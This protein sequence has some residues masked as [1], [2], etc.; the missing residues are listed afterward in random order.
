MIPD[1]LVVI[2]KPAGLTSQQVVNRAK[3]RLADQA[4]VPAKRLKAGHA[5]TLDP[6]ATGVLVVG[7]GRATRLLGYV[8]GHDKQYLATIRLGQA[9]TTDDAE[10]EPVGQPVDATGLTPSAIEA[11]IAP[12]TGDIEQV[13]SSVSAIKVDGKRAYALARAGEAVTLRSRPVTVSRFEVLTRHDDGP[14]VDMDVVVECSTGTY[15]RALARDL[16]AGLG[17]GGHLT[18]LRR[19]RVGV[20]DVGTAAA[21]DDLT[22]KDVR[23]LSGLAGLFPTLTLAPADVADVAFGRPLKLVVPADPTAVV[24]PG[25]GFLAL[26]RPDGDHSTPAVVFVQGV[27]L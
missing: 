4:G 20:F 2:D 6:M 27:K 24:S 25:G 12:L 8:A 7:V 13:P 26:Y 22:L 10:G 18:A 3:H 16:G 23:P 5:G 19:T 11:A 21:L 1:G 14:F 17:V 9:T 15:V